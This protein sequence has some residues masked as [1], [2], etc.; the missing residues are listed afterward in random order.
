LLLSVTLAPLAYAQLD[1]ATVRGSVVDQDGQPIVGA[2]VELE[3]KGETRSR[4]VKSAATDKKGAFIRV[5][6]KVGDWS[7]HVSKDGF[8]PHTIQTYLSGGSVSELPPITLARGASPAAAEKP[9]AS[10]GSS[11]AA[12]AEAAQAARAQQLGDDFRKAV[13]A[14][15]AGRGAEAEAAFQAILAAVPDLPEAHLNLGRLYAQRNADAEAEKELRK[16]IE[17]QPQSADAYITLATVLGRVNR[18]EEALKLLQD[19]SAR[20]AQDGRYQFALGAVAFNLGRNA[21]S[22]RAFTKAVE[23]DAAS[24]EPHFF[25]GSLAI[26]RNDVPAAVEHLKKY[27]GAAPPGAP[28]LDAAR[29][30]LATFEKRKTTK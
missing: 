1:V 20:F 24:V 21:E 19:Q 23:L 28:N 2:K 17:L 4:I 10:P 15:Q 26:A 7:L 18:G 11:G 30:L 22:E 8:Q 5:G 14:M 6:L 9:A 27:V 25:L 12:V 13:E 16:V 3:F 29:T